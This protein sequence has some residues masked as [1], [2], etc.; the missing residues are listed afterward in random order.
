MVSRLTGH[1][2]LKLHSEAEGKY[3]AHGYVDVLLAQIR[4]FKATIAPKEVGVQ[5]AGFGPNGLTIYLD[6]LKHADPALI[7]FCG[8]T[9]EG[10]PIEVIQDVAHINL[11]LLGLPA[12]E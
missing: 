11:V 3:L 2:K 8:T 9:R 1:D 5:I 12:R 6:G 7:T 4:Q 10:D